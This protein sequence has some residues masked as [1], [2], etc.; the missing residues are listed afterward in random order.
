MWFDVQTPV[1]R[2]RVNR[3]LK[4]A[5][6]TTVDGDND[7][8][9][10]HEKYYRHALRILAHDPPCV[11]DVSDTERTQQLA[12]AIDLATLITNEGLQRQDAAVA[13]ARRQ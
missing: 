4:L 1:W 11:V 6:H 5:Y 9:P 8:P 12:E 10:T 7:V 13:A 3:L 2:T